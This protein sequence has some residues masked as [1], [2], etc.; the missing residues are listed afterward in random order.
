M[1]AYGLCGLALS[2]VGL[3]RSSLRVKAEER[4]REVKANGERTDRILR[5]PR[6][7]EE[8]RVEVFDWHLLLLFSVAYRMLGSVLDA[9]DV[10]QEAYLRWQE[11][12]WQVFLH[13]TL[14]GQ[15]NGEVRKVRAL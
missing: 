11:L 14:Q 8:D 1:L 13:E 7:A 15:T 5:K 9:E 6:G 2:R 10:I 4:R 12:R 3:A